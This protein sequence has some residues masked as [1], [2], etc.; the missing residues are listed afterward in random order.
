MP[1]APHLQHLLL[2]NHCIAQGQP[3]NKNELIEHIANQA[4]LSKAASGRALEAILS[5]VKTT[6]KKGGEVLRCHQARWAHRPQSAYR[7]A[8]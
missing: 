8:D 4:D 2:L 7:R 5:A 6:L 3:V 1:L